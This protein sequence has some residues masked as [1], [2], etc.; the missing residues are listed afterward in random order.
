MRFE[1]FLESHYMVTEGMWS[2]SVVKVKRR[3]SRWE[4]IRLELN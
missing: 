1:K 3:L 2:A 4:Y